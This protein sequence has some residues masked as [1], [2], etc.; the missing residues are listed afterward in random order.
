[1]NPHEQ[2]RPARQP[3]A[4]PSRT[5][6]FGRGAS[7]IADRHTELLAIVYIRQSSLQQVLQHQESGARQYELADWAAR[8]G[9][10]P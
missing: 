9:W 10:P 4:E 6:A 8:L 1:M 7:K 2:D 3:S 5:L